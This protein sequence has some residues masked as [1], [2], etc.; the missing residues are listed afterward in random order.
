LPADIDTLRHLL[1]VLHSL[2]QIDANWSGPTVSGPTKG[3][4]ADYVVHPPAHRNGALDSVTRSQARQFEGSK[5][6]R[7]GKRFDPHALPAVIVAAFLSHQFSSSCRQQMVGSM[8]GWL[9]GRTK[10]AYLSTLLGGP[11]LRQISENTFLN[12]GITSGI[13]RPLRCW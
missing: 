3:A 8:V 6:E 5:H 1:D 9:D 2:K 7:P 4:F 11:R 10:L 13:I 12:Q